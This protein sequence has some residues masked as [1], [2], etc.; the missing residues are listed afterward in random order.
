MNLDEFQKCHIHDVVSNTGYCYACAREDK[1]WRRGKRIRAFLKE[2]AVCTVFFALG[3]GL[4]LI[5][6]T[7]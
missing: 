7:I 4:G 2:V 5:L 3:L 6:I 1:M